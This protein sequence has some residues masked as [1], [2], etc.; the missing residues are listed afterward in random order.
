M[1]HP[2]GL[3]LRQPVEDRRVADDLEARGP[4]FAAAVL[5][6]SAVALR[7]FLMAEA[8]AED[9]HIEIE[10]ARVEAALVTGGERWTARENHAFDAVEGRDGIFGLA[11]F[12]QHAL[13][14]DFRGDE[15]RVLAA[16]INNC[17]AIMHRGMRQDA[18]HSSAA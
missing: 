4:V 10:D 5:H 8:E 18:P 13:T 12:G 16:E 2:D 9:G 7:D 6:A 1:A 3:V 14:P 17:D 11:D 15:M